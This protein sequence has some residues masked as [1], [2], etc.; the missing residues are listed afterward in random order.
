MADSPPLHPGA[1]AL[2]AWLPALT[3]GLETVE[4][5]QRLQ[6]QVMHNRVAHWRELQRHL[7]DPAR[8]PTALGGLERLADLEWVLGLRECQ[9]MMDIVGFASARWVAAAS[10]GWP[11]MP[12]A[13]WVEWLLAPLHTGLPAVDWVLGSALRQGMALSPA[14]PSG[15]H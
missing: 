1:L 11:A 13:R 14:A 5:V 9:E 12:D 2:S 8:E 10:E 7:A 15:D 3:A 6:L 4:E